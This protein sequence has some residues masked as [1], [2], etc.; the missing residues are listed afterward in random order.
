MKKETGD[1]NFPIWLLGD[2][3]P[4]NWQ[5]KL[6]TPL[7]PRHPA[8]HNIWTPIIDIIQRELYV[9]IDKRINVKPI[10]IRN[11]VEDPSTKPQP[12]NKDWNTKIK[13]RII[14]FRKQVQDHNPAFV[15]SFGAFSFEFA[16]RCLMTGT[17]RSHNYW[18]SLRLGEEFRTRIS[19]FDPQEVNLIPLL[20][21]SIARGHFLKS[22]ENFCDGDSEANYFEYVGVRLAE[23]I[24]QFEDSLS[25]WL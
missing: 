5:D 4:K 13:N 6:D 16:R 2:S 12:N 15:F 23:K 8:V 3:N 1:K 24:I 7:D 20:H 21:V 14:D 25:V 17:V 18:G 19:C 22:H 9:K 11:A 10:Y